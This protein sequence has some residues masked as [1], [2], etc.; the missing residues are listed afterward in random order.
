MICVKMGYPSV[1]EEIEILRRV[2][3]GEAVEIFSNFGTDSA[4]T[5]T[6]GSERSLCA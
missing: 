6:E 2:Q 1:E 3:S 4:V 5:V